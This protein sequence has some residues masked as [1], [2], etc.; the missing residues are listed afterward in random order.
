MK[1]WFLLI[2]L[3]MGYH[4]IS[5][6]I[7]GQWRGTF[8]SVN[9]NIVAGEGDT[10]YVLELYIKGEKVTGYS[11]SYFNYPEK[12]YY[13]ICRLD[14]TYDPS[15]KSVIVNEEERIKGNT[16][17]TWG[18]CL[19]THILTFLKQGST[20]KLVGRWRGYR[21]ND[22][23]T[24]STELERKT[25]TRVTTPKTSP[26]TAKRTTPSTTKSKTIPQ[27]SL[28]QKPKTGSPSTHKPAPRKDPPVVKKQPVKPAPVTPGKAVIPHT[29]QKVEDAARLGLPDISTPVLPGYAK[30][31]KNILKTVDIPADEEFKVDFYDN[32]EIDGDTISV[33]YNNKLLL[34]RQRL[35]DKPLSLKI[36]LDTTREENEL[37][38]YAD[39]FGA[40]P[41]N[42]ALMVVTAGGKR[43]E[44]YIT[45]T[46]KSSGTILFRRKE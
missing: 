23:G 45:S 10:E 17:P 19:Q 24:G 26:P 5:Q 3:L 43:Y 34:S 27:Q 2:F 14:G 8:N 36:K 32:G 7:N 11:Y 18:D 35:T 28:T 44:V 37:V 40:I 20:E 30:R 42:T 4:G 12:R 9:N 21:P 22:C 46:E 29:P 38:M 13:V 1:D 16:P 39:N 33:F 31:S 6:D 41:P 25:L 15:S